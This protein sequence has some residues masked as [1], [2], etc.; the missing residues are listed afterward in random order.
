MASQCCCPV[1]QE[2]VLALRPTPNTCPA[3]PGPPKFL[4]PQL[5][6]LPL[7]GKGPAKKPLPTYQARVTE[8]G[9][10]EVNL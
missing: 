4:P 5:P 1:A 3:S 7:V 10:I 2:V 6:N 8:S 9:D